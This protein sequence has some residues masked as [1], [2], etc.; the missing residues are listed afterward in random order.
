MFLFLFH[1]LSLCHLSMVHACL[2]PLLCLF[3]LLL[4][5]H[6]FVP[7]SMLLLAVV[8]C[9]LP[10]ISTYIYT[11][12][13]LRTSGYLVPFLLTAT[14]WIRPTWLPCGKLADGF[15]FH[16]RV[17]T[18][19]HLCLFLE[20]LI[21]VLSSAIAGDRS[22]SAIAKRFSMDW[23]LSPS[24]FWMWVVGQIVASARELIE[25]LQEWS[26]IW[27]FLGWKNLCIVVVFEEMFLFS[28][29]YVREWVRMLFF[30]SSSRRRSTTTT[31]T[32][33]MWWN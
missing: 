19:L 3:S 29:W 33:R 11:Q 6:F 32:R 24:R 30:K 15:T 18:Y 28:D 14:H 12:T 2:V 7:L 26:V 10:S 1:A 25:L 31:G 16:T 22:S 17:G 21:R 23:L 5:F 8:G 13:A 27:F 9:Q 20:A 4:I